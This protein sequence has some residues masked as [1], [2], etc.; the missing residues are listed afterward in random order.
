MRGFG[1]RA[2]T[3]LAHGALIDDLDGARRFAR[4]KAEPA[5]TVGSLVDADMEEESTKLKALQTQQ[6][7]A[8]QALSIANSNSQNILMLFRQ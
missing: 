8:V 6:Q 4:S 7:L 5:R 1:D 3:A 2:V